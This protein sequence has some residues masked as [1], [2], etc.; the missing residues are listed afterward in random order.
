MAFAGCVV[1]L[2]RSRVSEARVSEGRVMESEEF[3]WT[4]IGE[5]VAAILGSVRPTVAAIEP[6]SEAEPAS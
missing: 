1:D 2:S 3:A 4:G 5:A 6:A